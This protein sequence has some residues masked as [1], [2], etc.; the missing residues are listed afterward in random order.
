MRQPVEHGAGVGVG[1]LRVQV[2]LRHLRHDADGFAGLAPI[3][4]STE[5]ATVKPTPPT[6][7]ITTST[8]TRSASRVLRTR[9][10]MSSV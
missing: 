6:T 10:S 2:A 5:R 4:R 9:A 3:C 8:S 1:N 7:A